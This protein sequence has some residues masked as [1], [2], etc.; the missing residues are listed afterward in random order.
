MRIALIAAASF[1]LTACA[2]SVAPPGPAEARFD[3]GEAAFILKRGETTLRGQAFLP[4]ETGTVVYSAGQTIRL[5]P[6]TSYSRARMQRL[7]GGKK[8]VPALSVPKVEA[9][10]DY[11][12]HTRTA[13]ADPQGR[14][15]F[16]NV[17]PGEYFITA[18]AIW[19][20]RG[21]YL[22]SGGVMYQTARV[23]GREERPV[24]VIVSGQ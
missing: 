3:A 1:L 7:Y 12:K 9:D 23:T 13:V 17:A 4:R 6:A 19:K 15:T 14:F 21:R 8:F 2:P 16:E 18:Q 10:P 20:E 22:P 24:D 5:I 11:V